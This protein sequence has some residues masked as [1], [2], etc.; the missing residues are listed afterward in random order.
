MTTPEHTPAPDIAVET[1]VAT[2]EGGEKKPV[3]ASFSFPFK[4]GELLQ[5]KKEP[6]HYK[7][8]GKS[9]HDKRPGAAPSG[10]RRSMGKR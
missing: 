7:G 1:E 6:A 8:P 2:S 9:N 4:P 10:T 5:A 3:I